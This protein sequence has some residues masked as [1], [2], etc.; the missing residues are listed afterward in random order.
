MWPEKLQLPESIAVV[1]VTCTEWKNGI[2]AEPAV[3]LSHTE[4]F[5][6]WFW[7]ADAVAVVGLQAEELVEKPR[8]LDETLLTT[9]VFHDLTKTVNSKRAV[10]AA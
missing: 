1:K 3:V 6:L 7:L 5:G 4:Q 8:S 9:I 2:S 10:L